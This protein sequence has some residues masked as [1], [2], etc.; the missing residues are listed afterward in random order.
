MWYVLDNTV[1]GGW[2]R[3][4]KYV[5]DSGGL[6]RWWRVFVVYVDGGGGCRGRSTV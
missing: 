2:N 3:C 1:S 5:D 4:E 6:R